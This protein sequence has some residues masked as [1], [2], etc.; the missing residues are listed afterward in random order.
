MPKS[1]NIRQQVQAEPQH[2]SF[3]I[4]RREIDT[5]ARTVELAF[6]SEDPY[7]RWYGVEIL[8]HAAGAVRMDRM[9]N[10]AALLCDH[11]H[12]DQVGV[13]ESAR[14]D[15]DRVGRAVVRFGNSERAKEVFQDIV[16]GIKTKVSVG[17]MVH[18]MVLEKSDETTDTYRV[19][20]WE[21]YEISIVAVPA[22]DTVGVGRTH[23]PL[24]SDPMPKKD[25][26]QPVDDDRAIDT[27]SV[28]LG[29]DDNDPNPP[30]AAAREAINSQ[31]RAM[32]STYKRSVPEAEAIAEEIIGIDGDVEMMKSRLREYYAARKPVPVP[33]T[34]VD[35]GR[36]DMRMMR[37]KGKLRAFENS[38]DGEEA[39][40]RSGMWALAAV[41]G[42]ADAARWCRDY[43]VRVMTGTTGGTSA[44]VP[45]EMILP[46][47]DLREQYGVARQRCYIHPMSSDTAIVPRRKT[48]V[49]AYFP[50]RNTATEESDAAFDDVELVARE[51][52]ALTRLANSYMDDSAIDL[53]DHLA[54]EMA[55]AFAVKEDDCLFNG[56]GTSTYGGI[57]GIRAKIIDGNH[58]AGA[59]DAATNHDTFAEIDADDLNAVSGALPMFAGI[60]PAWYASKKG[61]SL[62]IK[63]IQQAAGGNT[64]ITLGEAV[65]KQWDGDEVVIAQV[66]PAGAS[67]D[68]SNLAMLVY[69]DLM[70]GATLGDRMGFEVQVLRERYAEYRQTGIIATERMDINVHGLGDASNAGPIVA[71][72]GE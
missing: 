7:R 23:Q 14:I 70:M 5:E 11:N 27:P 30:Q 38:R 52:S 65:P 69:G 67:T 66:M 28:E 49:T 24:R 56:D 15:G 68:Y 8:D 13:V 20:D 32:A 47:I 72:I 57:Y 44:V 71:L 48:G 9:D 25:P 62:S 12:R 29:G 59:I 58:A 36:I 53:G 42:K 33:S 3:N 21:P 40:Y 54:G 64:T 2:R 43:G 45:E 39:A 1:P 60:N 10:K 34:T 50:G 16:D 6:S 41:F 55:Y 4:E 63:A 26:A 61:Y 18:E 37:R 31:I 46:I 17:Y 35:S 19:T 51:V 22:D